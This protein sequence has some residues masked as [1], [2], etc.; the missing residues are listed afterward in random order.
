VTRQVAF[1]YWFGDGVTS[2][3]VEENDRIIG[4]YKIIANQC[5]RGSH[6]AN[7]S[8]MIDPGCSGR[9]VG[10]TL[11]LHCLQEA[12]KS[13]YLAMQFNFVVSTN[14]AAIALWRKLGFKTVGTLPKAF[15]HQQ[16]GY[17]DALVMHRFLDDIVLE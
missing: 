1:N 4:M 7:A 16:L 12:K 3:V 8:F 17:V 11:A 2:F 14:D 15:L 10:K 6:V 5:D 13:G 9:G